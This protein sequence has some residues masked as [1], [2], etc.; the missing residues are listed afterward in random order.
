MVIKLGGNRVYSKQNLNIVLMK[1]IQNEMSKKIN[2]ALKKRELTMPQAELLAE[3]MESEQN[4][5]TLKELEK[6]LHLSQPV[7]SEIVTRLENKGYVETFG[8]EQDKRI[9]VVKIT[10]L[11]QRQAKV[12]GKYIENVERK[13]LFCLTKNERKNFDELLQKVWETLE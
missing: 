1:K 8:N 4:K 13:M 6:S 7:T 11:G 9:K 5:M 10:K 12:A 3:L 2:N